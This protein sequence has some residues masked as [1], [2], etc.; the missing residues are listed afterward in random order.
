MRLAEDPERNLVRG[1]A[2]VATGGVLELVSEL[3]GVDV[4]S[5]LDNVASRV[6]SRAPRFLRE[7]VLKV[8]TFRPAQSV[9]DNVV[10]VLTA[11][12]HIPG[13]LATVAS[14]DDAKAQTARAIEHSPTVTSSVIN[15]VRQDL[16]ALER[17]YRTQMK[18]IGKSA[19]WLRRGAGLLSH[20]APPVSE[21][22]VGGVFFVGAGYVAYS[23]TD[24][25][26]ARDLGFADRVEGVVRIVT[27]HI[28]PGR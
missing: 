24:R 8:I 26:D 2:K 3:A 11:G 5:E 10:A 14:L 22:A 20:L 4:V 28:G 6:A 19:R 1:L 27:R 12:L 13:L 25:L 21:V 23:L 17:G 16:A 18:W 15:A 9:V 7:H